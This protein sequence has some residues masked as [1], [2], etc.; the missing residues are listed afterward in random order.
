MINPDNLDMYEY[1]N[2]LI[3][4]YTGIGELYTETTKSYVLKISRT[5]G[6]RNFIVFSL[7]LCFLRK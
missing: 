2:T 3:I 5:F 7:I 1:E 6:N 4:I